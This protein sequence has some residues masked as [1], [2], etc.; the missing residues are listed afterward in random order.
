MPIVLL[1]I[2]VSISAASESFLCCNV[3]LAI[4]V[5][6][7]ILT[8]FFITFGIQLGAGYTLVGIVLAVI[9]GFLL[10]RFLQ[11]GY[12]SKADLLEDLFGWGYKMA[13][14]VSQQAQIISPVVDPFTNGYSLARMISI[15]ILIVGGHVLRFLHLG[16]L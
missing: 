14:D 6:I 4:F 1:S 7:D 3:Y 5:I 9:I 16:S 12:S 2:I 13:N 8:L 10:L 11:F 15:A